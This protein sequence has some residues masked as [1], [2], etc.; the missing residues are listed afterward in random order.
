MKRLLVGMLMLFLG[1]PT[2]IFGDDAVVNW[3]EAEDFCGNAAVNRDST[4][5][6]GA[7][8]EGRTWC[9][10]AAKIPFP[11]DGK[12]YNV[13]VRA[14]S[15]VPANWYL[16]KEDKQA[17]GWFQTEGSGKWSWINLGK[18]SARATGEEFWPI[19]LQ[20]PTNTNIPA[21]QGK[22]DAVVITDIAKAGR[23]EE[24]FAQ[25]MEKKRGAQAALMDKGQ[26]E[27]LASARRVA[28][29]P[30]VKIPPVLDGNLDDK[31]WQVAEKL[32]DFLLIEGAGIA[33][34]QTIGYICC[35]DKN[36]YIAAELLESQMPFLRKVRTIRNDSV[37]TDDCLEIFI[38]PGFTQKDY[39]QL[40]VN[41]LGTQEDSLRSKL[42]RA[43]SI[44]QETLDWEAKTSLQ[45]D[46][47]ITE[48]AIPWRLLDANPPQE[49]EIWGFNLCREERPHKELSFWNNCGSQ[50][51]QP[52]RFGLIS[53]GR[54]PVRLE[55]VSFSSN[56]S[57]VALSIKSE[58]VQQEDVAVKISVKYEET[59]VFDDA[60][61]VPLESGKG[62]LLSWPLSFR[63][64]G[65]YQLSIFLGNKE[66]TL[67]RVA[68]P[69][70]TYSEG[71]VSVAWP[72]EM[73]N[74]N[75]HLAVNTVQHCFFLLANH[76]RGKKTAKN[77]ELVVS[78]PAGIEILDPAGSTHSLYYHVK[79]W[80]SEKEE[81]KE[82]AYFRYTF[83]LKQDIAPARIE[84]RRFFNSVLL[85]F[86]VKSQSCSAG[87][88]F[89]VYYY[90]KAGADREEAKKF[91]L[92]LLPQVQGKQPRSILFHNWLWTLNP[93]P[94][95]WS[96]YIATMQKTGFN[97][98]DAGCIYN[99]PEYIDAIRS[100]KM[101]HVG[102]FWWFWWNAQ[103]LKEHP[104]DIAVTYDGKK[105]TSPPLY[106]CPTIMLQENGRLLK[107]SITQFTD[108]VVKKL[109]DGY[110]WD[111]EGPNSWRICFCPRCLAEFKKY[112]SL[113]EQ[114][115]LTPEIIKQKYARP[116]I[117]FACHQSSVGARLIREELKRINPKAEFGV[118]SGGPSEATMEE[119]RAN[120]EELARY[121][122]AAYMSYYSHIPAHLDNNFTEGMQKFIA[123]LKGSAGRN[124]IKVI[125]TLTPGYER[126]QMLQPTAELNKVQ[127]LR[128][129]ATGADGVTFWWWGPFDGKYYQKLAE[130]SAL[131]ADFEEFFL[132]GTEADKFISLENPYGRNVSS[133]VRS[134]GKLHLV[135][136]FNHSP[137]EKRELALSMPGGTAGD[138]GY[139]YPALTRFDPAG[140]IKV[141]IPPLD[142]SAIVVGPEQEVAGLISSLK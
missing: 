47:W 64:P 81:R 85:F 100:N 7:C 112:A 94:H 42:D 61:T 15:D 127:V 125:A 26:L 113:P 116:W 46:R 135:L 84:S 8:V 54:K 33:S 126:G 111:L 130:A 39:Y 48:V 133:A 38:D 79:H 115:E 24:L 87:Q 83:S 141:T 19:Y 82:G 136:L 98:L 72:P 142:V 53:F 120:W 105:M 4:A 117:R 60:K 63:Q 95:T 32:A 37:W 88:V 29:V 132:K 104:E 55:A 76:S 58:S 74:D 128:S 106:A 56:H 122:D 97:S 49:G 90:L 139:F 13:W 103:H 140:K 11:Q 3:F 57:A 9:V 10:F 124:P 86:Q 96:P 69:F 89:P 20:R 107:E 78:V 14:Q 99:N 131:I 121:I 91:N 36:L 70:K 34:E 129:I 16:Q 28:T 17:F 30:F 137:N 67:Y 2:A 75:L 41:P 25:R 138:I 80:K 118:Y 59:N 65:S 114:A 101:T 50:F 71:L 51:H 110:C 77:A 18:Y 43:S 68:F 109:A 66:Q 27:F 44:G 108:A 93:G 123:L 52:D 73:R 45:Q 134:L 22:L 35:D 119:Y 31:C 92:V 23:L 21:A 6:H 102:N 12:G 62:A 1:V 5:S 40:V